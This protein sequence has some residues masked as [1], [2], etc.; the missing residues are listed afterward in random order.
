[1]TKKYFSFSK[2]LVTV[3]TLLLLSSALLQ[4]QVLRFC[5][6]GDS[7]SNAGV[8]NNICSGMNS[9]D[10]DVVIHSGDIW[11][12]Y[13]S[14]TWRNH[15]TSKANLNPVL[16]N[17]LYMIAR[18]NH[19][20]EGEVLGFSPPI[21]RNNS[22]VY[23]FSEGNCFFISLGLNPGGSVSYLENVLQSPEAQAADWRIIFHHQPVYSGGS[24]GANGSAAVEALCDQYNVQFSFA[25]H[26]HDYQRTKL[27][28]GRQVVHSGDD[29]PGEVDGTIYIVTGGGGAGLRG[30][31]YEW[32]TKYCQSV[33]HYC[34]IDAYRDR[35]EVT[36]RN[37]NGNVIDQFI[38][39]GGDPN[40]PVVEI[41]SP[42]NGAGF[43]EGES[44]TIEATATDPDGY[45]TQVE[46]FADGNS[47][48]VD[49]SAPY[50]TVWSNMPA[51]DHTIKAVAT[52]NDGKDGSATIYINVC[53]FITLGLIQAEDY[54]SM[55][56]VQMAA[57]YTTVGWIDDG[58]WME[59]KV[60]VLSPGTYS[61][62]IQAASPNGGGVLE[63]QEDGTTVG[64]VNIAST[65]SWINY[66]PFNTVI[67]LTAGNHDLRML[68][69]TGGFNLDWYDFESISITKPLVT[70]TS[71]ANGA[72]F[73]ELIPVPV[74]V[75]ASD[76]NGTIVK[77]EFYLDGNKIGEDTS[78]PYTYELIG[79]SVG[80]HVLTAA[81]TD[82]DNEVGVSQEVN[83]TIT[84]ACLFDI[85]GIIQAEDYCDM[86]GVQGTTT[87][88]WIDDGDWMSYN[89]NVAATDTYTVDISAASLNGG[90]VLELQVGGNVV[91]TLNIPSTGSWID[92]VTYSLDVELDEGIH[93]LR[94]Y[95]A[96]G[97][98]NL[99][100]YEFTYAQ[101]GGGG[102]GFELC[103]EA[104]DYN[105]MSG[106]QVEPCNDEGGGFNV[107]Q[108]QT[109]DWMSYQIEIPTT[110]DYEIDY[111]VTT[112]YDGCLIK[113]DR[114]AGS[115]IIDD[116]IPV[117]NT[118]GWDNWTTVTRPISLDAGQYYI[119]IAARQGGWNF[120]WFCI[121]DAAGKTI[122][123]SDVTT[124][125]TPA[126][127]SLS[128]NYP[129]PFNPVTTIQY[130]LPEQ[131]FVTL[132]VYNIRGEEVTTLVET[133]QQ[134][135]SYNVTFDATELNS[136][137]Y[138]YSIKA[139]SYKEVKRMIFL[140]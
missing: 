84:E 110:G 25:G 21:V 116:N 66:Q 119:G 47:I 117:P 41:T 68:A 129:N 100:W 44:V 72:S 139:G 53:P 106:V 133:E 5:A 96:T 73:D 57:P 13:G 105:Y 26:D 67:T 109:G 80:S 113:L 56:G 123:S 85:P 45:I 6:Y 7:R 97:G 28:Y 4:G 79:A 36:V 29:I 54:C 132:K 94:M 137:I 1:M 10:P 24:H 37:I 138:F 71:P 95:A 61:V 43:S 32:F 19:E 50:S 48:G 70:I 65:G 88:G 38:R 124:D 3:L 102:G 120:N 108:I 2:V 98:F 111:R 40:A 63:I 125:L 74:E 86:S 76:P 87:I 58:D 107:N 92:Y 12:G 34:T 131:S 91:G 39:R 17:N 93:V 115:T 20:S 112:I 126:T 82:N 52:D 78:E 16:Q 134:S 140:K 118:G 135:G 62:D 59:Y 11:S 81:A 14:S 75:T 33:Y 130:N 77:V 103:R 114:D 46:F 90:G 83:I 31:S 35:C 49:T 69:S 18:G 99:D 136:G 127:Y 9:Q 128:Q 64:S 42:V 30:V 23:S 101:G 122:P 55:Q 27:I 8:H 60:N 51:G 22:I 15:I 89:V 104:E 121:R